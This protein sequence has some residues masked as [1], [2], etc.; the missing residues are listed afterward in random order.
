MKITAGRRIK[1]YRKQTCRGPRLIGHLCTKSNLTGRVETLLKLTLT[2]PSMTS[3]TT[4][5]GPSAV[6]TAGPKYVA[7]A[8]FRLLAGVGK[9]GER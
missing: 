2:A 3:L 1:A 4:Y 9:T 8:A 5:L 6:L 7:S